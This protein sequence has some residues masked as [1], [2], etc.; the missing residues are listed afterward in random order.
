M[1]S[2]ILCFGDYYLPGFKFGG[3]IRSIANLIE[4]LGDEFDFLVVTRD[5][6]F[7]EELP[8]SGISSNKWN[9]VGKAKV[10]YIS[11]EKLG[12]LGVTK[13][14]NETN[15]D[16]LYLNSFFSPVMT[17]APLV[18]QRLGLV[19]KKPTLLAPRGEFSPGAL[20]L[21]RFKKRLFIKIFNKLGLWHSVTWQATSARELA[22]IRSVFGR[23]TEDIRIAP[24]LTVGEVKISSSRDA[25]GWMERPRRLSPIKLVFLS[26]ISRKKN[27]IFLL[28]VLKKVNRK[29][30]LSIYGPLEDDS[31]WEEC[32]VIIEALPSCILVN[33]YGETSPKKVSEVFSEHDLFV[34]P[35]LGENFGHVIHESLSA[36]TPVLLSDQTPWVPSQSRAVQILPLNCISLWILRIRE[37]IDLSNSQLNESRLSSFAYIKAYNKDDDGIEASRRVFSY[38]GSKF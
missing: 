31:Y 29:L 24:N 17:I 1:K 12:L 19:K 10:F 2:R 4:N 21:K 35:T 22:D 3:P 27:L 36:G 15:Y 26:R 13:L 16:I 18:A 32:K 14:L 25:I 34:F 7:Q 28:Q 20:G 37:W 6:D 23:Q 38:L 11:P 8:Y 5:R 30:E 33:Y 9:S